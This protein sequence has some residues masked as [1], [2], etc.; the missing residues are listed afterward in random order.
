M[1]QLLPGA[2]ASRQSQIILPG[3]RDATVVIAGAGMLGSW[4]A[5]ALVRMVAKVIM[6]DGAD[7]VED[8]NTGNQAYN[9]MHVGMGKGEALSASLYGLP[10]EA[11]A[12]KF[13]PD[14]TIPRAI[15]EGLVVVSCVDDLAARKA[16]AEWA[17][18][19]NADLFIDTR[20]QGETAAVLC[21][22]LRSPLGS[23]EGEERLAEYMAG[24]PEESEVEDVACGM[25]GTAFVGMW[26]AQRVAMSINNHY[27]GL[28]NPAMI[29][30]HVGQGIEVTREMYG[31]KPDAEVQ[32]SDVIPSL[33]G[34]VHTN[35]PGGIEIGT[36]T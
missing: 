14:P 24:V 4:T 34:V 32:G 18:A 35:R 29:V 3:A 21:V 31:A 7:L 33:P 12:E 9:G 10:I 1:T 13:P 11:V 25:T 22:P 2:V 28:D 27:R 20:A 16:I 30:Y 6:F 19:N 15:A 36:P 8:V 17:L 5:H 26:V 23:D